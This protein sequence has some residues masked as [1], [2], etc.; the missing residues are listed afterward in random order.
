MALYSDTNNLYQTALQDLLDGLR[1]L[2][3]DLTDDLYDETQF[4]QSH[5]GY[6]DVYKGRSRRHNITVAVK[7]IR[8]HIL[9]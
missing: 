8:V 5:G 9:S 3:L 2:N 6:S 1:D 7:C 4:Q